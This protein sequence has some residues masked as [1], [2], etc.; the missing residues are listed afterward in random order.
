MPA[1]DEM[2][3]LS[4]IDIWLKESRGHEEEYS[5]LSRI[6]T[7]KVFPARA[8][9]F[10]QTINR[11]VAVKRNDPTRT[12]IFDNVDDSVLYKSYFSNELAAKMEVDKY[13]NHLPL[14]RQLEQLK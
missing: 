9:L 7:A 14:Y 10:K 5:I 8:K 3:P 1:D 2:S 4:D 6:P 12:P 13:V 11:I